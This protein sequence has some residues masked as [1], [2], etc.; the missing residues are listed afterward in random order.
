MKI[1]YLCFMAILSCNFIFGQKDCSIN[2]QQ[3]ITNSEQCL[4]LK[5]NNRTKK[6][7]EKLGACISNEQRESVLEKLLKSEWDDVQSSVALDLYSQLNIKAKLDT[8][9]AK[10]INKDIEVIVDELDKRISESLN[11]KKVQTESL[12][13]LQKIYRK[14]KLPWSVYMQYKDSI[15]YYSERKEYDKLSEFLDEIIPPKMLKNQIEKENLLK[16]IEECK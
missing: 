16:L 5:N 14:K 8:T 6:T 2:I 1:K 3:L 7:L 11:L 10:K 4:I 9:I 12:T 15:D 13:E